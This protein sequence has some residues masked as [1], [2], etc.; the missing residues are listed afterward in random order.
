MIWKK[1][2]RRRKRS[3]L[4]RSTPRL[5]QDKTCSRVVSTTRRILKAFQSFLKVSSGTGPC[6]L[7]KYTICWVIGQLWNQKM[8]YSCLMLNIQTR[9]YVNTLFKGLACSLTM[10]CVSTCFSFHKHCSTKKTITRHFQRC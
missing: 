6:K 4:G 9:K 8:L 5:R 7:T 2:K 10:N 3:R 1:T